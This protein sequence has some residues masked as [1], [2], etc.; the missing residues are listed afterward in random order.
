MGAAKK[1]NT[2]DYTISTYKYNGNP[3][4]NVNV[5]THT[6][7][8]EGNLL[9]QG[10]STNVQAFDTI[11]PIFRLNANKS[12]VTAPTSGYSGILN[13]RGSSANVG[14]FWDEDGTY[15]GQWIANNGAGNTGPILTSYNFKLDKTTSDPLATNNFVVMS[16]NIE[17]SGGTGLYVNAGTASAELVSTL[18]AKKIAI[19]FG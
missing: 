11:N 4:G 16:G 17:G 12:N 1:I 13:V 15:S 10:I 19:I 2:G 18:S 6:L 8:I 9:V 14:I 5:Q 7:Y 3:L